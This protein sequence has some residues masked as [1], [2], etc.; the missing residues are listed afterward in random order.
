MRF[1]RLHADTPWKRGERIARRYLNRRGYRTLG[2]NVLV[3][4]A[5]ADIIMLAPDRRT[6]VVVEVKARVGEPSGERV[7]EASITQ[8]KA[9][10]LVRIARALT[11]RRVY[12]GR[13]VRIDVVAVEIPRKGRAVVRHHPGAVHSP[14]GSSRA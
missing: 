3:A 9:H 2:T 14:S 13:P 10:R 12:E 11:R 8:D 5:E 6:I 4:H 7:P 1:F